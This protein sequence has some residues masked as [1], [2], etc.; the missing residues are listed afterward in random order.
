MEKKELQEYSVEYFQSRANKRVLLIWTVVCIILSGAYA[1][2]VVKHLRTTDYYL[3]FL[4]VAWVPYLIG[5]IVMKIRGTKTKAYREVVLHGYTIFYLFVLVTSVSILSYV[6]ILPIAC[7]MVVYKNRNFMIRCAVYSVISLVISIIYHYSNGMN[8]AADITN[9]E[10]QAAS[11]LLCFMGFIIGINHVIISDETLSGQ[12]ERNL[13]RVIQTIDEVKVA[14]NAVVDGVTVVRDLAGEN[15]ESANRVSHSMKTLSENNR[16]LHSSTMSSLDMS[17]KITEQVDNMSTL[18]TQMSNLVDETTSHANTSFEELEEAIRSTN[19]MAALSREVTQILENFKSEFKRVESETSSIEKIASQ[20]NLLALNAAVEAARAGEAGK[21]FS[22]VAGEIRSLSQNTTASSSRIM[23]ALSKLAETSEK[24]TV[25]ISKTLTL[26][27]EN[28]E[29]IGQVSSSV[30]EITGDSSMLASN[31]QIVDATMKDIEISNHAMLDT[32]QQVC[33]VMELMNESVLK[34]EETAEDMRKKYGETTKSVADIEA[35]VGKLMEELGEGGLMGIKDIHPGMYVQVDASGSGQTYSGRVHSTE[36]D[37]LLVT[38]L[39]TA[40][41]QRL[42]Q[43]KADR[44]HLQIVVENVL[45]AWDNAAISAR[46]DGMLS[47]QISGNPTVLNR[48]KYP[49]LPLSNPCRALSEANGRGCSGHLVN[50]SGNGFAFAIPV[51]EKP[52]EAK[53]HVAVDIDS[54]AHIDPISRLSGTVIRISRN[55]REWVFGCRM[56]HDNGAIIRY[57]NEAGVDN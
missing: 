10:I 31:I 34:A 18:V 17:R 3:L 9:Y 32:V 39:T 22:V 25:S 12:V 7:V 14:S 49:C 23:E 6:Y 2:E 45:Y 54:F 50:I 16:E 15:R 52:F 26:V 48:R 28:L 38:A 27:D 19:E 51:T 40:N 56:A 43:T 37:S 30:T 29:K 24:M 53:E 46:R 36:E 13:A 33:S 21:G 44:F 4:A 35:V 11:I 20:T 5:L 8:T 55:D 41:G 42:E 1:L 47:I 57:V